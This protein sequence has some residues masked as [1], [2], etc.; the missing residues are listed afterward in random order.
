MFDSL[1]HSIQAFFDYGLKSGQR[2]RINLDHLNSVCLLLGPYR[3][4]TTLTASIMAL[5]P[6][7]QVLNHAGERIYHL[8]KTHFFKTYTDETFENFCRY[9]I[10]ISRGGKRGNYGGSIT[11]SHAFAQHGRMG[12]L[13]RARYGDKRLKNEIQ[14]L[15]WKESMRTSNIIRDLQV[16]LDDLFA[17]NNKI[18]FLMPIRNPLDCALSNMKTGH[19]QYINTLKELK[20]EPVLDSILREIGWFMSLKQAHPERF[21]YYVQ[22]RFD[23][24]TLTQLAGFLNLPPDPQWIQDALEVYVMRKPYACSPN[25]IDQYYESLKHLNHAPD[26]KA[27]LEEFIPRHA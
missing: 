13:Y 7:C 16:D 14:C 5:H 19:T 4:L 25:L 9:A 1:R 11:L 18:R 3:N 23:A 22:N 24:D 10:A 26:L 6:N 2:R 15:F 27:Q 12:R 17:Q 21:F 20:P 8:N